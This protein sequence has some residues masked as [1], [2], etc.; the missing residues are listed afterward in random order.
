MAKVK[1]AP[2][3]MYTPN[4]F[5][6]YQELISMEVSENGRSLAIR[7]MDPYGDEK[8]VSRSFSFWNKK[9]AKELYDEIIE[10]NNLNKKRERRDV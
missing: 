8:Y 5:F 2:Y 9:G 3:V 7:F 10:V 1:R 6:Y 4:I